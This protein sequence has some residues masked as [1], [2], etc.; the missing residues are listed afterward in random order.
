MPKL[1]NDT[2]YSHIECSDFE[3][4][5]LQ[6]KVLSRLQFITQNAL[7]YFAFPSINTK[8]YIHSI[9]TMHLG[10]HMYKSALINA[11]D[12]TTQEFMNSL[13]RGIAQLARQ[14]GITLA[15]DCTFLQDTTLY[16]FMIPLQSER[17]IYLLSLQALRIAALLHDVGH[18]PFSHQVEF[19]MHNLYNEQKSQKNSNRLQK[20]FLQKYEQITQGSTE[21]LHEAAGVLFMDLLFEYELPPQLQDAQELEYAALLHTI[22]KAIL[23]NTKTPSFDFGVLHRFID[24][25]VDADR[26]DYINRDMLA[27]GYI[28]GAVDLLRVAKQTVLVQNG[29]FEVSFFEDAILDIEHML[30]MRFNLYKKVIFN[31]ELAKKDAMLEGLII[32]LSHT[33]F[34]KN[35]A[36]KVGSIAMLWEFAGIKNKEKM[37]D[38]LSMLDE[39]WLISLFKKEYFGLKHK[40]QYQKDQKI[41][42]LYEEVLFGKTY[43]HSMWK[44]LH[45]LYNVLEFEKKQRYR[46]RESFGYL[47]PAKLTI[48]KKSLNNYVKMYEAQNKGS[49]LTYHIVSFKLGVAKDFALYNGQQLLSIDEISTLR[50]RLKKS[51]QNTVPFFIY[52]S[53]KQ[54][55]SKMKKQLKRLFF[56]VFERG[57][58]YEG[59]ESGA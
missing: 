19:A 7:A 45:D 43:F 6:S 37:L 14:R 30:E 12:A 24:G 3:Q 27:S 36:K 22:I 58:V 44:N 31:H 46:F 28:G 59:D 49:Y 41:F 35:R 10:A 47:T 57:C 50:K 11:D 5:L 1:I 53:Q 13:Q 34:A 18:L 40:K 51:M 33:Y 16:Q 56:D 25:T 39:N 29:G 4:L 17:T 55:D 26:L 20:K 23:C 2:I 52:C 8:R 54:L 32:A 21:I 15:T 38:L 9:G 48:L 42:Y